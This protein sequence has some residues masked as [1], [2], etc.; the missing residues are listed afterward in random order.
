MIFFLLCRVIFLIHNA[1]ELEKISLFEI[2]AVFWNA[3]HLDTST[4]CYFLSITFLLFTL[5]G[6]FR[7]KIFLIFNR[8]YTGIIIFLFS[9]IVISELKIYDEWGVKLNIKA[10]SFL[11]H[12]SE[13]I[14]STPTTFLIFGTIGIGLLT[15]VGIYLHKKITLEHYTFYAD[16]KRKWSL[17]ELSGTIVFFFTVP[18][19]IGIGIRGGLQQIPIQQSDAY[20]SKHN[21]LNLAA[22]N[23]GWNLGQ[24]FMENRMHLK[25]N[26]YVYFPIEKAKANT[27]RLHSTEKDST[28]LFLKTNRPN[29]VMV[30]LEGWSA[31]VV[32]CLGGYDSVTP[33]FD[34][35]ASEGI[36]FDS[37]YASGG[38]SD[39]GM[40]AIFSGFPALPAGISIIGQ[41]SKYG[42]LPCIAKELQK[43]G[44]KTSFLFGGQLSYGNI[45]A[46]MYFN[47]FDKII[48]GKDFDNDIPR[49]KLCI[50]DEFVY[51]RQIEELKGEKQPFLAALFTGSSHSPYDMPFRQKI[52]WGGDENQYVNSVAYADSCLFDFVQRAKQETWFDNTLFIFVADHSH[53][54]PRG[55]TPHQPEYR[56]IPMLFWGN[57]LKEEYKGYRFKKICSQV[58]IAATLLN[59]LGLSAKDFEWSKNLFNPYSPEFAYYETRD[60]FGFVRSKQYIVYSHTEKKFHYEKVYS[61]TEKTKMETEGKS[62]LQTVFQQFTDY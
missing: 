51:T 15:F 40:T 36:L 57:V 28:I 32:K 7:K 26:P 16:N 8:F 39:Q 27:R 59:Q 61:Q 42:K 46:Y 6:F 9:T 29:I 3:V 19:L 34:A 55:W 37:I 62:Y 12:P 33:G 44:Y 21:V 52:T 2:L 38:L 41:P 5:Y 35:L 58:D 18:F 22:V 54:S 20:F 56:R 23:S 45:K 11:E 25:G 4:A 50:H 47:N 31:D 49:G 1:N 14:D 13:V 30:I 60:G 10:I 53:R 43:V 17:N 48:E 24:S